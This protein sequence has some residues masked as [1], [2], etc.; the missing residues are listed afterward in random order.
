MGEARP[1]TPNTN[2]PKQPTFA[3]MKILLIGQGISGTW[4][5]Y[6]LQQSGVEIIV[7]DEE[8]PNS[9]TR[10]ASGLINPLTGRRV[11]ETWMADELMPFAETHYTNMGEM[12]K[13]TVI[14]N[15]GIMVFPPSEEM[16]D[17]YQKRID[18]GS[19][20]VHSLTQ[21]ETWD[22]YFNFR[23][24]VVHIQPAYWVD[25]QTL[26]AGW[27][28]WLLE[29]GMLRQERFDESK[30]QV[31]GN[32]VVYHDIHADY[33]VYCDGIHTFQSTYWQ[34]LPYSFNKGEALIVSIDGLPHGQIY[35][36]GM[37]V[38]VPWHNG[39][40]WVGSTYENDYSDE[41]PTNAFRK[42]AE[43]FLQNTLRLPYTVT[44]HFAAIRPSA[45]ERRP[46]VG[47]HPHTER[48]GIFNGMGSKGV[49]LAP[50]FAKEL[51]GH[52][53]NGG[54]LLDEVNVQRFKRAFL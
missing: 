6:W 30:L 18:Q 21:T 17:A 19:P 52:L 47:M 31:R 38:L 1:Y 3:L 11:V 2:L 46:F 50:Y 49:S 43:F 23:H 36:F 16:V 34:G 37:F 40:W 44:D 45:L 51:A 42:R 26:L 53:V 20:Y 15:C 9:A 8:R 54:K 48:V 32:G 41:L 27:R 10:V 39:Q 25:L 33:M 28:Q 35:K 13:A 14:S 5:S 29:N 7:I 24:G 4:L 22:A 12:L